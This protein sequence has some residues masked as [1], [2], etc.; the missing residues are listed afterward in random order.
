MAATSFSVVHGEAKLVG[1]ARATLHEMKKLSD[2]DDQEGL[3]FELP[4]I[5]FYQKSFSDPV[6][7]VKYGLSEALEHYYPLA[8]RKLMVDCTGEGILFVEAD[9][10]VSLHLLENTILPP[11]PHIQHFLLHLPPSQGILHC[12]LLLVQ[13]ICTLQAKLVGNK[14]K[15]EEGVVTLKLAEGRGNGSV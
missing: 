8:D 1:A 7:L 14:G 5:M 10:R 9:A 2:I 4:I 12:P 3:Q 15:G 6:V 13:E 11:C